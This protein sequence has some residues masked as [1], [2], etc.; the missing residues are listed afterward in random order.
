MR[1]KAQNRFAM[2][3]RIL[4]IKSDTIMESQN[5]QV[6]KVYGIIIIF[7]GINAGYVRIILKKI[8]NVMELVSSPIR[9]RNSKLIRIFLSEI[10]TKCRLIESLAVFNCSCMPRYVLLSTYAEKSDSPL[11]TCV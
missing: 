11:M 9:N 6:I 1:D 2:T 10:Q 7:T 4:F 5:W 8:V 3:F